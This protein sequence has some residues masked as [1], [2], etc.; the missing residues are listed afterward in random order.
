M[1]LITYELTQF[2]IQFLITIHK[3]I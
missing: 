3:R 1:I 2:N